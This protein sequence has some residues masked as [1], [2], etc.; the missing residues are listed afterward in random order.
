MD[1][2]IRWSLRNRIVVLIL[3]LALCV[4]GAFA[5]ATAPVDVFPD[6]TAPTVT[7]LAEAPGMA[8]VEVESLITFPI[9]AALNGAPG[10]RRVRSFSAVGIALVHAEFEWG[11]DVFL[12]RQIVTEKL[13]LVSGSLPDGVS[14]PVLAP[15]SSIMGEVLFLALVSPVIAPTELRT[16]ADSVVRRRLLAV[17]GVS[18]VTTIG[19]GKREYQVWLDPVRLEAHAMPLARVAEALHAANTNTAAGFLAV[20][21]GEYLV[22]GSGR[23]RSE[24]DIAAVV[25]D[26]GDGSPVR[27]SDLGRVA[28]GAAATRGTGSA[29]A[30][31]A[32]VVAIQKQPGVN[33]LALTH[34]LDAV[35]DDLEGKLPAGV[36]LHRDL[37][38]QADFIE[39]AMDNVRAAL[40]DGTILVIAVVGFFLLNLR[41]TAITLTAL[42][43]SLLVAALV[44]R[45]LGTGLNTMTMGGMAI[46]VGALVDDA[47]IDVENVFRRLRENAALPRERRIPSR[48]VVTAASIEIRSSIVFATLIIL[49]VF[50][51]IFFLTGVEGRLLQPLGLAYVAALAASLLVAVS[52]TPVLCSF[53]LPAAPAVLR[54]REPMPVRVLKGAYARVI[55]RVV[56][57]PWLCTAPILALLGLAVWSTPRLGNAFLPEFNEGA[58]T[59]TAVTLPGTSLEESDRLGRIAEEVLL[60]H[61]EVLSVSRRTGRAE[62]DEHAEGVEFS[63]LDVRLHGEIGDRESFMAALRA[64]LALVPGLLITIGQ[65]ISHRIDH[66]LSGSR[67]AVAVKIFGP[68]LA[69]LRRLGEQAVRAMTDIPGVVDL[70]QEQ[71]T[72]VPQLRV[73][74][75]R[76]ALG[77][78]GIAVAEASATLAAAYQGHHATQILQG[79][80]VFDVVLRLDAAVADPEGLARLPLL[81]AG[82]GRVPL[83]AVATITRDAATSKIGRENGER[84]VVVSCNLAGRDVGSVVADVRAAVDPVVAAMPG[85]RVEYGGQ[86]ESAQAARARLLW[87]GAIVVLGIGFL[88]RL[89]FRNSRDAVF[90]MANLPLALIGGI[91]GVWLGGGVLSVGSLIGFISVFGIAARNGIMLVSHIR[92]LMIEEGIT[93][94]R[95]A[96]LRGSEERL[97]PILMTALAAALALLPLALAGG[98][99]GSEIQRPMALVILFGLMTSTLLN[100]L[101]VPSLYLRFGRPALRDQA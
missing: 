57:H 46:A 84:R 49:L 75:D 24:E 42:P 58:L 98:E 2:I 37:L 89:A 28:I 5:A 101:L 86:F 45:A 64:D 90:V 69:E 72:A 31:P 48:Q 68:D 35:L 13:A 100:M 47:V 80:S 52:V 43:L 81:G 61:P 63:E 94:F 56:D 87:L 93:Q 44:L 36:T 32:V 23:L 25:V 66:M 60:R 6:L 50:A 83:S 59:L 82:G 70:A 33:T 95:A 14:E 27:V 97:L 22:T 9:E 77:Q 10:V 53:L 1:A 18:Q 78:A 38:R 96:V 91:A 67:A 21:G 55:G 4:W 30:T 76:A 34:A 73:Q 71:Q 54:A 19:G 74:F 40:R 99:P 29:M 3:A 51:P 16:F 7:V 92:H 11:T 8:P 15:V 62:L 41:A 85:Y 79:P 39:A 12:A 17:P 65:P 26:S 88:L 20:R